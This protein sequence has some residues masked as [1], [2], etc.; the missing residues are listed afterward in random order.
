M[1]HF[2][3]LPEGC[4]SEIV[5][6]TSPADASAL[7]V[8]SKRFKSATESDTVWGKFLPSDIDEII[9]KSSTPFDFPHTK[10]ELYMFLSHSH[11]LLDG[12]KLGLFLDKRTGK[13]CFI[14]AASA[15][16]FTERNDSN[17]M[18]MA[19]ELIRSR[20]TDVA[21]LNSMQDNMFDIFGRISSE[22]LSKETHYSS[23]LVFKLW[24]KHGYINHSFRGVSRF[25]DNEGRNVAQGRASH[26]IFHEEGDRVW[27]YNVGVPV[28]RD[29]GWL[30]VEIGTFFNIGGNRGDVE[31][32]VFSVTLPFG[33]FLVVGG[34]EFR[35]E[36]IFGGMIDWGFSEEFFEEKANF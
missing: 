19:Q 35:P 3:K 1:D 26:L 10:K 2:A 9:S 20:K 4:I 13:K 27:P 34:I 33:L 32:C 16:D 22:K 11:I 7:S 15:L 25:V 24:P 29:D 18:Y 6:F 21:V 28:S 36:I 17:R 5:S 30:E 23:Y 12:G 14:V 31:S 8:I